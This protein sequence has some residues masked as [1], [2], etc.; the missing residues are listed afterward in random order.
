MGLSEDLERIGEAARA[1]AGPGEEVLGVIPVEPAEDLRVYLCAYGATGEEQSWLAL[2]AE[3]RPVDQRRLLRDAVAIAALCEVAEE[4]AGGGSLEELRAQLVSLRLT[5]QPDGIE[6]AEQAAL[7]LER[8]I[9]AAPRVASPAYLDAVG[10][11]T[12]QLEHALGDSTRSPFAD[13][14]RQ[15]VT[16]VEELKL[17]VEANYKLPLI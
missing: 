17:D 8:T 11:A 10:A 7:A 3:G 15:A 12:R 5:E 14:M 13:A 16:T 2:D 4:T 6:E 9:G 1:H